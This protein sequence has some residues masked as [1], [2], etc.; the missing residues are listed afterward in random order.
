MLLLACTENSIAFLWIVLRTVLEL[1]ILPVK[2]EVVE[3]WTSFFL[4]LFFPSCL[5]FWD[6]GVNSRVHGYLGGHRMVLISKTC[7]VKAYSC[8]LLP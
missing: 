4:L 7:A 3:K 2:L 5:G 8:R 1:L 6:P